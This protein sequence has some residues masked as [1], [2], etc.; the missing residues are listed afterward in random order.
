MR[1]LKAKK[2]KIKLW[3][4]IPLLVFFIIILLVFGIFFKFDFS[5]IMGNSV[6]TYYYCLDSSYIL[7]GDRCYKTVYTQSAI[8]GDVNLDGTVNVT[9][10]TMIQKYLAK[11]VELNETQKLVADVNK[12][13]LIDV[14][15]VTDLQSFLV[16]QDNIQTGT[17]ERYVN[18]KIGKS[19]ICPKTYTY[20]TKTASCKRLLTVKAESKNYLKGDINNDNKVDRNDTQILKNYLTSGYKFNG[21][22]AKIA[23]YNNDGVVDITDVTIMESGIQ[24]HASVR[25]NLVD[26]ID[27]KNVNKNTQLTYQ[28]KFNI[29]NN[30]PMYYEWY[31]ISNS[32]ISK[33]ECRLATNGLV[34]NFSIKASDDNQYVLLKLYTDSKCSEV[35]SEYSSEKIMLKKISDEEAVYMNYE[36][37]TPI[38]LTSNIVNKN[39]P[40][41]FKANFDVKENQSYYLKWEAI[42]DNQ[43]YN[44]PVCVR[45]TDGFT[46]STTLNIDGKDQYGKWSI[47][48]DSKCTSLV[49]EYKTDYYNYVADS[50]TIN[51]TQTRLG[52][53]STLSLNTSI[54]TNLSNASELVEWT[55][56]NVAVLQVDNKGNVTAKKEGSAIIQATI[57]GVSDK[58]EIS[59]INSSDDMSIECPLIKY[60][61]LNGQTNFT[62]T[63]NTTIS[64]Y[65][66]YLSTNDH[67]GSYGNFVSLKTNVTGTNTFNNYHNNAYSNQAKLVVYSAY[68]TS[69]NCYTPPL[70]FKWNTMSGVATCPKFN[71]SYDKI[72]GANNYTYKSGNRKVL[73]GISKMYVSYKLNREYQ[74]SWYTI[75]T[76]GTY[77]LFNTYATSNE[78]K[79][80]SVTAQYYNRNAQVVVTDKYGNN[81]TCKTD[82]VNDIKFSKTKVGSTDIYIENSYPNT[83][84]NTVINELNKLNN[85]SP[86]YLAASKVFLYNNN[87]Y[88]KI[89]GLG[90]CGMYS[91][92]S[93]LIE[94]RQSAGGC[95]ENGT[96]NYFK[97]IIK[98]EFGHSV[99]TMNERLTGVSL[100]SGFYSGKNIGY[101]TSKY[102]NKKLC[103][104]NT[105]YC[106]RY[107][108]T[109]SY[110]KSYWEFVA[111][112]FSYDSHNFNMTNEL[113]N[114]RKQMLS[115][116]RENYNN[117]KSKF[118]EIKESFK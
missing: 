15:D 98:H 104:N 18:N 88:N 11:V 63:P 23:D 65:D 70:T 68:G 8:L 40:I 89:Y 28:A 45:I 97:G 58:V 66:V 36:I 93:N 86:S 30:Q 80:E 72:L 50:I 55:S 67:V 21:I 74:Y 31:D 64:K 2:N 75:N 69:R 38:N 109:Y 105:S 9:D 52:V 6:L 3:V 96:S 81:I 19:K 94:I 39:T 101:Y 117:S 111:D 73:S 107:N 92:G 62:I 59:V 37:T 32:N 13:S 100:S 24:S 49:K 5:K 35:Y 76:D 71:Y 110:G 34:D 87:T 27:V 17:L 22:D 20:D 95:G 79:K 77:K 106:L 85:E 47:Y 56:S 1:K 54:N 53:G 113:L 99:D 115:S 29:N 60:E 41:T 14:D 61:T 51:A 48:K 102:E 33:S 112:I 91:A 83:E 57:G 114:L 4:I 44:K 16:G 118:N 43:T 25:I 46:K 108:G 103:K 78:T 12:D 7:K 10:V 84:K 42:K 82:Y 116:Y 90:S 26:K